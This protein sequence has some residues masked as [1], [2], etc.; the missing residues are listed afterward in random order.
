MGASSSRGNPP[1]A[2]AVYHENRFLTF[3]SESGSKRQKS[4]L[5]IVNGSSLLDEREIAWI[6]ESWSSFGMT[7]C[8]DGGSNRL[9]DALKPGKDR[10]TFVP[11]NIIGDLDS[12]REEVLHHYRERGTFVTK[13][14]NQD[15]MDLEKALD[16]LV[17]MQREQQE[18]DHP[19][20]H[21]QKS[22]GGAARGEEAVKNKKEREEGQTEK[23]G[24]G[25]GRYHVVVMGAFGGRFDH[26]MA[27]C[28]CLFTYAEAFASLVLVGGGNSMT[29]LRGDSD[30]KHVI[31]MIPGKEGPGCSLLP[32]GGPVKSVTTTGLQWDLHNAPMRFGGLVSSS[33]RAADAESGLITVC[34]SEPLVWSCDLAL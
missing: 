15:L 22:R 18:N 10:D 27:N 31:T 6:K 32:L 2:H 24:E 8:A 14:P 21:D 1:A 28:N 11:D 17:G 16:M 19:P 33:N 34:T 23:E 26:E 5:I 30:V 25:E 3:S 7:I 13:V 20:P 12:I 29:L 9:H 4:A